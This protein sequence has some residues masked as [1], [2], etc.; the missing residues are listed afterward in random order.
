MGLDPPVARPLAL[1]LD[2][3]L[4]GELPLCLLLLL[5][6]GLSSAEVAKPDGSACDLAWA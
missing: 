4:L 6:D 1:L 3:V 5:L 2:E